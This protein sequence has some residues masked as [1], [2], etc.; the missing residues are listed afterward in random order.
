MALKSIKDVVK[1]LNKFKTDQERFLVDT[2]S[3]ILTMLAERNNMTKDEMIEEI[4]TDV[5]TLNKA[6]AILEKESE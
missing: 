6:I 5:E 3:N 4:R 2:S 1:M